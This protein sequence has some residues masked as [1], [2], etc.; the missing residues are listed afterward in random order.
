MPSP[1]RVTLKTVSLESGHSIATVSYA[2]R[3]DA[4]IPLRT[5]RRIQ[6][7]AARLGYRANPRISGLMA[8]IRHG[9]QRRFG[10]TLAFV[11]LSDSPQRVATHPFLRTVRAGARLQA[12]QNGCRLDEF[13][14]DAPGMSPRRLERIL[15]AR[16]IVGV[17]IS[18]VGTPYPGRT[19]EWD[20]STF[21]PALIGKLAWFPELHRAAH[22]HYIGMIRTLAEL[23]SLRRTR[24][25]AILGAESNTRA[26]RAWE[27]ALLTHHPAATAAPEFV[28]LVPSPELDGPENETAFRAWLEARSPDAIIASDASFFAWPALRDYCARTGALRASLYRD[29]TT[30]SGIGGIN[31]HYDRIAAEAVDIVVSQLNRNERGAPELPRQILFHGSWTPPAAPRPER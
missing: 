10:D 4:K 24:P 28:R 26:N 23:S 14:A 6:A 29:A 3:D 7:V 25:V 22:H 2:L 12:A 11:W 15:R 5:R 20:W 8:H 27:A 21:A 13:F 9:R 31:Q 1:P 16:G 18:P 17:V 19:L 30:P